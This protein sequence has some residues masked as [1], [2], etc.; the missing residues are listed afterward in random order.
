MFKIMFETRDSGGG[1]GR[2]EQQALAFASDCGDYFDVRDS[3]YVDAIANSGIGETV[4]PSASR[5]RGVTFDE[6]A[7]V[8]KVGGHTNDAPQQS[9]PRAA[10][11]GLSPAGNSDKA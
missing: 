10:D 2:R 4:D 3:R 1:I 7:A 11:P 8:K 9:F 5:F 6:S